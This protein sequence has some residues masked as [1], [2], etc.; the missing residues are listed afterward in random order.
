MVYG[1]ASAYRIRVM[2]PE[3][4]KPATFQRIE[5]AFARYHKKLTAKYDT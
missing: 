5:K 3:L 1:S 2:E 4:N